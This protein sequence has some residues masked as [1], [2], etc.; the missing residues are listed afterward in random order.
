M[1]QRHCSPVWYKS[2]RLHLCICRQR[3]VVYSCFLHIGKTSQGW[4]ISL[5][6]RTQ[7]YE[8]SPRLVRQEDGGIPPEVP[9]D[10]IVKT[11]TRAH[12]TNGLPA[13]WPETVHAWRIMTNDPSL[14]SKLALQLQQLKETTGA[15]RFLFHGVSTTRIYM[16]G[17]LIFGPRMIVGNYRAN[18]GEGLCLNDDIE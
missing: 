10:T 7:R 9:Y 3:R 16:I 18:F 13:S 15:T 12:S 14:Q 6:F 1:G 11:P 2:R 4:R 8:L 5:L 17:N